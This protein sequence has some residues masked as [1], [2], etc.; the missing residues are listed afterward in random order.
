M[1]AVQRGS[2][3]VAEGLRETGKERW[4]VVGSGCGLGVLVAEAVLGAGGGQRRL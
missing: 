2:P 3:S 4:E 1:A